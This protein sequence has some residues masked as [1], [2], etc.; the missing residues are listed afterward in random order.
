MVEHQAGLD[1]D[2]TVSSPTDILRRAADLRAEKEKLY[3]DSYLR[4]GKLL[5]ALFPRGIKPKTEAELNRL[6]LFVHLL[7]KVD[8]YAKAMERGEACPESMTDAIVY[9][10]LISHADEVFG[11]KE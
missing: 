9:A 10:A 2:M 5:Q 8:R 7:T 11:G 4:G 6:Y 3:G 1:L